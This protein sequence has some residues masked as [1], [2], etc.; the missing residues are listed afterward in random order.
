MATEIKPQG[1]RVVLRPLAPATKV[2]SI[3]LP[4]SAQKKPQIGK[5][6][7]VASQVQELSCDD[8]VY[9][10]QYSG[11]EVEIEGEKLVIIEADEIFGV[12]EK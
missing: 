7:A 1:K 6:Y 5:V 8:E 2:G 3:L 11:T 12:L 4:E 9:Y 10:P